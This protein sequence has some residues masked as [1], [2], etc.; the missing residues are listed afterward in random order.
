MS[1][2]ISTGKMWR[3]FPF[4]NFTKMGN[5]LI[6]TYLG[7]VYFYYSFNIFNLINW[8][9][10]PEELIVW[11][12]QITFVT[13]Y[14]L[15]KPRKTRILYNWKKYTFLTNNINKT[16]MKMNTSR[17]KFC[18][19]LMIVNCSKLWFAGNERCENYFEKLDLSPNMFCFKKVNLKTIFP[20]SQT[21]FRNIVI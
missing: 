13:T 21:F 20:R 17:P 5:L 7:F 2:N 8:K 16:A 14:W 1:Q 9:N 4:Q 11:K 18:L 12:D 3:N 6:I 15:T 10:I 19:V